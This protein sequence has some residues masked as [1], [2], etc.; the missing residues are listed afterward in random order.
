MRGTRDS[1]V[2]CRRTRLLTTRRT[3]QNVRLIGSQCRS[4]HGMETGDTG[5]RHSSH[6]GFWAGYAFRLERSTFALFLRR[7]SSNSGSHWNLGPLPGS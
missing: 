7:A 2:S 1:N 4:S 3:L 5:G 6:S